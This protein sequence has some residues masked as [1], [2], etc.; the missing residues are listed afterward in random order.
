MNESRFFRSL[1]IHAAWVPCLLGFA[2]TSSMAQVPFRHRTIADYRDMRF[3]NVAD[4]G[5]D[6][7][8]EV[9]VFKD[10]RQGFISWYESIRSTS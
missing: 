7:M 9:L 8:P 3:T 2:T 1:G 6:K 10:R 5:G 4:L